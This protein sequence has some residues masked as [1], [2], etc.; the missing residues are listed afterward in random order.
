[1]LDDLQE[2]KVYEVLLVTASNV[3]PVGVVRRGDA[4]EFKLFPGRSFEDL[5][6]W[7]FASIQMT[8][9]VE[10]LVRFALN[11]SANVNIAKDG[12][13]RWIEGIPGWHG[14]V[15]YKLEKWRDKLGESEV[16]LGRFIPRGTI[17]GS[18]KPVPVSRADCYLLE[19][20][21]HFTRLLVSGDHS[22]A[23]RILELY[24]EYRRFG[25]D[26]EVV[27]YII[28]QVKKAV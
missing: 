21:V 3:T 28:E 19:M 13:H 9:D 4:L 27:D 5:L 20:A 12:N 6:K 18:L 23:S 1:M 26:S 15:E 16:L 8:N 22:L 24:R 17:P 14:S 11:M 25:G 10:L 2:G 7:P